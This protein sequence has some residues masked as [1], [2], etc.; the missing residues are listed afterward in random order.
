MQV[1]HIE[2]A[3][4]RSRLETVIFVNVCNACMLATKAFIHV[5]YNSIQFNSIQ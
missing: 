1:E 5:A 3:S 2:Y 4:L